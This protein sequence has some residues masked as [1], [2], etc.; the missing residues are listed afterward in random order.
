MTPSHLSATMSQKS[1]WMELKENLV[2]AAV[3]FK[4]F[5]YKFPYHKV[6]TPEFD[7]SVKHVESAL[8]QNDKQSVDEFLQVLAKQFKIRIFFKHYDDIYQTNN[9]GPELFIR[10][11]HNLFW[12]HS[13]CGI[14]AKLP[15]GVSKL[16]G[17]KHRLDAILSLKLDQKI[18][19]PKC[20]LHIGAN[21]KRLEKKYGVALN[22]WEK[23]KVAPNKYK[24]SQ[25]RQS[26]AEGKK[27]HLHHDRET[28]K[29]FLI[30]CDKLYFRGFLKQ[31]K[32]KI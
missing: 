23:Q 7:C 30:T 28:G 26:S 9:N 18:K 15:A 19:I 11:N 4:E 2:R 31:F 29:L 27:I 17:C 16:D 20:P 25:T 3:I 5:N 22:I 12:F 1:K 8:E 24:I 10:Q 14:L 32:N 6:M 13:N 21:F